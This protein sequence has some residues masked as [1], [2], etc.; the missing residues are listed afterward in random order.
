[1]LQGEKMLQRKPDENLLNV[2]FG[3]NA[4]QGLSELKIQLALIQA[5]CTLALEGITRATASEISIRALHDYQV[6]ASPSFTGQSFSNMG[7]RTVTT[8]GKNKFI[9][10]SDQLKKIRK[11]LASKCEQAIGRLQQAL[12]KFQGLPQ[13]IDS[14]QEEWGKV[15]AL[16]AKEQELIRV[17]NA[18]R[19]N[20]SQIKY[21]EAEYNKIQQRDERIVYIHKE[22]ESLVQKEKKLPSLEEKKKAIET[23]IVDYEKKAQALA[24]KERDIVLNE[25]ELAKKEQQTEQQLAVLSKR[26]EKLAVKIGWVDLATLTQKIAEA[27][28][29][30]DHLSKQLGEKRSLLD[31][32]LHRKEG[33]S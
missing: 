13:K 14:L 11:E 29:E 18:D 19:Q 16:R 23:R 20:P 15:R 30:L 1:L 4:S 32:L 27:R 25:Q 33:G 9:L 7:I 22:I 28:K 8:H 21:L 12:E 10:D 26:I 2:F 6:E 24:Q 5:A 17:I 31:K 3:N